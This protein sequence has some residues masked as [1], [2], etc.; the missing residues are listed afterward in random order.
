M[1]NNSV[2]PPLDS[3]AAVRARIGRR[4]GEIESRTT[5]A[6]Q[7]DIGAR[8]SAIRSKVVAH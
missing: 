7:V 2:M 1:E 6:K 8:M 5:R 3:L 4:L